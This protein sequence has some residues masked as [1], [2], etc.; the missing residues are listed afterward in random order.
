[1]APYA[2]FSLQAGTAVDGEESEKLERLARY[3]TRYRLKTAH[4]DGTTHGVFAPHA[5]LRSAITPAGRGRGSGSGEAGVERSAPKHVA[6]SWAQ[7]WKRVF[8]IE[9]GRCRGSGGRL[10]VIASIEEPALIELIPCPPEAGG[11]RRICR[12]HWGHGR[13]FAQK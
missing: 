4:R 9:I 1:V 7:R 3:V 2:G 11:A 6:M 8:A 5:A 12:C 10:G 13:R